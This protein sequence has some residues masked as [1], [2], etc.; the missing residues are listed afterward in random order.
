MLE[1]YGPFI[2]TTASRALRRYITKSDDA[3]SVAL[4]AFWEAVDHYRE[5]Q[6]GFEAY[7][8]LVIRRRL[9][10]YSRKEARH[11]GETVVPPETFSG[12]PAGDGSAYR[13]Q[14]RLITY[15]ETLLQEEIG[16]VSQTL[17]QY[18]VSFED[19]PKASP[20]S[21]K[22]KQACN[23]ASSFMLAH[24]ALIAQMRQSFRLPMK[25]LQEGTALA[26]KV[27][28]RH[29]SYIIAV[30]EILDGDYPVLGSYLTLVR[31]QV[32]Q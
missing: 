8:R 1:A 18:G 20:K 24:P 16:E 12:E 10:D 26:R 9:V 31:E 22:T 30:V 15:Q 4:I 25:P 13:N 14:P 3:W 23:K 27:L 5:E 7:A 28:E 11:I 29:R 21:M 6:G 32:K 17:M 2:L 19:L